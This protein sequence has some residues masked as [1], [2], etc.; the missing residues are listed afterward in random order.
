LFNHGVFSYEEGGEVCGL[1]ITSKKQKK[2]GFDEIRKKCCVHE[3]EGSA[4]CDS[5]S[6]PKGQFFTQVLRFAADEE[7]WLDKFAKA[8]EV[9]TENGFYELTPITPFDPKAGSSQVE[10]EYSTHLS[11][12]FANTLLLSIFVTDLF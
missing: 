5:S 3:A 8:W 9:A 11:V 12:I 10:E 4:D 7:L 1:R 6:W 2:T